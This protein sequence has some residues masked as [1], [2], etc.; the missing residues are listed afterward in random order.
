MGVIIRE[1]RLLC[2]TCHNNSICTNYWY[3]KESWIC[4]FFFF[5]YLF[6]SFRYKD[7]GLICTLYAFTR[8]NCRY[9]LIRGIYINKTFCIW[10]HCGI[11]MI[12]RQ[13]AFMGDALKPGK[14]MMFLHQGKFNKISETQIIILVI[15]NKKNTCS[16]MQFHGIPWNSECANFDDTSS[17]VEF[18]GI[19]WNSRI[20]W[21]TVNLI[22]FL[23]C[24][25][26]HC[27]GLSGKSS[28]FFN[29]QEV[30]FM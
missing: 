20:E 11:S 5:F 14:I 24:Q 30:W 21:K 1:V 13:G 17:S 19:P 12:L 15:E 27:F 8:L 16:S 3:N 23:G 25:S 10:L 22:F 9:L 2:P 29:I 26:W 18:H 6:L 7:C 28:W 4:G